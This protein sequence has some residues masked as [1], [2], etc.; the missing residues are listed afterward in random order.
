V[1][2]AAWLVARD[3]LKEYKLELRPDKALVGMT[4]SEGHAAIVIDHATGVYKIAELRPFLNYWQQQLAA[5][6]AKPDQLVAFLQRLLETFRE[7]PQ[8]GPHDEPVRVGVTLKVPLEWVGY[9]LPTEIELSKS[10]MEAARF[11]DYYYTIT[12]L[13]ARAFDPAQDLLRIARIAE[14]RLG[15]D[16][17]VE[18]V[19]LA[20]KYLDRIRSGQ[21][22][23]KEIRI[24]FRDIGMSLAYLPNWIGRAEELLLV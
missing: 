16:R 11:L 8:Y 13:A 3:V 6:K 14:V 24:C 7:V 4:A 23:E 17:A 12:P 5:R 22:T 19:P 10:A 15:L 20:E 2:A 9:P 1:S 21:A 18:A